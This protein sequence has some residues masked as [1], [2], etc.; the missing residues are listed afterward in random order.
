MKGVWVFPENIKKSEEIDCEKIYSF[1]L[2]KNHIMYINDIECITLGHGI[3][4]NNVTSHP[5]FA[6]DLV[7]KDLSSM[8]GWDIGKITL[9]PNPLVRDSST[10]L[11]IKIKK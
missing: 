2:N 7:I 11:V 3:Q 6:T 5:Y 9:K 8:E 1:V 4:N 10:G